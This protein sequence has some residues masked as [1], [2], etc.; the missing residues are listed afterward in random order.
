MALDKRG[1][2]ASALEWELRASM[3]VFSAVGTEA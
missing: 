1:G 2:G 3:I